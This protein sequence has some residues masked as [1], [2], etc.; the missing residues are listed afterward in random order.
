MET[1]GN[2]TVRLASWGDDQSA[3]RDVRR[4]VFIIEQQVPE[5][6]EWDDADAISVHVL[7]LDARGLPIGT[8]RLLAD[9]QIGRMAVVRDWRRHGVGS[10]ILLDLLLT[11]A[12]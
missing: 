9:G 1:P 5:A 6:L 12:R 8:G 4:E 11:V 2:F 10:T 3:L 7:A